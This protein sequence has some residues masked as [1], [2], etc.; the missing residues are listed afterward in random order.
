MSEDGFQFIIVIVFLVIGAIRWVINNLLGKNQASES[1]QWDE[2]GA[3]ERPQKSSLEDLYEEARRE[4]LDRQNHNSPQQEVVAEKLR[5]YRSPVTPPPPVPRPSA[6]RP[7]PLASATRAQVAYSR[8]AT[9]PP[10]AKTKPRQLTEAEREA[11]AAFEQNSPHK[12]RKTRRSD[13]QSVRQ[14]L[15]NPKAARQAVILTELL[16]SPKGLK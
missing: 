15:A 3:G 8:P 1:E 16:G 5:D 6:N 7:P 11:A 12:K 10:I 14:Q 9:P 2:S 13:G 4:I